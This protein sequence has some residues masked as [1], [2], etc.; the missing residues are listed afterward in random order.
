M[1]MLA[2]RKEMFMGGTLCA[3][4]RN[5]TSQ[6]HRYSA[7]SKNPQTYL[8]TTVSRLANLS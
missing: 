1:R 4:K 2:A 3:V 7:N 5:G 6:A 8:L